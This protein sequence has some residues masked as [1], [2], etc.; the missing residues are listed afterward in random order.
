MSVEQ[1]AAVLHHSAATG[2]DKLVLVGIANHAGDGGA[3][4]TVRTLARYANVSPRQVQKAL[5]RLIASGELTRH[6]Q[7]GGSAGWDDYTRPNRYDVHVACPDWCDRTAHH[8][9]GPGWSY[10]D[11]GQVV[12]VEQ[13]VLDTDDRGV[14]ISTG[15]TPEQ[16]EGEARPTEGESQRTGRGP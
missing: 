6:V 1:L 9:P 15:D 12:R 4:P 14:Q 11:A 13:L 3:W 10:D 8:R 7:A 16:Q 5:G 2:T